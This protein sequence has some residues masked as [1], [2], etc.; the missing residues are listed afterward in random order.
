MTRA[1]RLKA[2]IA[3]IFFALPMTAVA[4]PRIRDIVDV[5]GVREN[6]LVGYRRSRY[7]DFP[8]ICPQW[9]DHRRNRCLHR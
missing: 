7:S 4:E 6:D 8:I 2:L 1:P 9:I 5:E 3:A